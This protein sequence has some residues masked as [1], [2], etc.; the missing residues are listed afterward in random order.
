MILLD[1]ND[2][3]CGCCLLSS[4]QQFGKETR[5]DGGTGTKEGPGTTGTVHRP[6]L[7]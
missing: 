7:G 4:S 6:G 2:F 5:G 3:A 1:D